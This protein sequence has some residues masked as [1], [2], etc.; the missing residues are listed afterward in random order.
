LCF[1][2]PAQ[3]SDD[4]RGLVFHRHFDLILEIIAASPWQGRHDALP[5]SQCEPLLG[6]VWLDGVSPKNDDPGFRLART[7]SSLRVMP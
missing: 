6:K 2:F 1:P 5:V 7:T 4:A 3:S